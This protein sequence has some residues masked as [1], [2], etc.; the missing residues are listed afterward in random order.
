MKRATTNKNNGRDENDV[1]AEKWE[2]SFDGPHGFHSVSG[3]T[4]Q[5]GIEKNPPR[6][7]RLCGER[8]LAGEGVFI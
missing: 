4:P 2:R 3:F 5:G 1:S 6:P 7:P 8:V